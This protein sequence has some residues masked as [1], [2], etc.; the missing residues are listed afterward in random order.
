MPRPRLHEDRPLS[1]TERV[2]RFRTLGPRR[3]EVLLDP[4]SFDQVSRFAQQWG[5][6]RQEVLTLAWQA[7]L[8]AMKL[9][10]TGQEL[11]SRVRDALEAAGV[12]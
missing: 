2:Q 3:L 8:P 9:A 11:F 4:T 5:C 6:S 1:A 10:A 7:C 12:E